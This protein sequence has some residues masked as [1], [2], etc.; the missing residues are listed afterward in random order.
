MKLATWNVLADSYLRPD[1]YREVPPALLE[2]QARLA[3]VCTRASGLEV[4]VLCLQEVDERAATALARLLDVLGY[5]GRW[6]RKAKGKPDG[7]AMFWRGLEARDEAVLIYPD[8]SGHV[9][10]STTFDDFRVITTHLRWDPPDSPIPSRWSTRQVDALVGWIAAEP[11]PVLICGDFNVRADDPAM[12]RFAAAGLRDVFGG[13]QR[14]HTCCANGR[15]AKID[16]WVSSLAAARP[17]A[18]VFDVF[19][20][21]SLP[22]AGEPSDHVPL[23]IEW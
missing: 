9:A 15:T 8:D 17:S 16:H 22:T 7:C 12:A 21:T 13:A 14:P 20:L 18:T 2:P 10:Q 23:L 11:K 19:G 1:W 3:A 4:D 6:A 5:R